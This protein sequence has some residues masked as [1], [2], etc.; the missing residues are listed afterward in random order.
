[1]IKYSNE[2][3][4]T[5]EKGFNLD[6]F[7]TN[8]LSKLK[9][10]DCR[11]QIQRNSIYFQRIVRY[12]PSS[13]PGKNEILKLLREG[14][15]ETENIGPGKIR[16]KWEIKLET[17]VFISVLIGLLAGFG[18]G[19]INS[20]ILIFIIFGIIFSLIPFLIGYFLIRTQ[21]DDIIFTSL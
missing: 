15:I 13:E 12:F 3:V 18:F 16:I 2:I 14:N 8:V 9:A 21:I 20:S 19:F 17:L 7:K 6:S 4:L 1:M 11:V 5:N 10:I